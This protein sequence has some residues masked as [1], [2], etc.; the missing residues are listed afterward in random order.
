M[1]T[2]STMNTPTDDVESTTGTGTEI[3]S[4]DVGTNFMSSVINAVQPGHTNEIDF[5]NI[6]E[7]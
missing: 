1:I 2:A 3:L 5:G 4:D 7:I 6:H